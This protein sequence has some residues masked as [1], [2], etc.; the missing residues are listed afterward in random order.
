MT[1]FKKFTKVIYLKESKK[2]RTSHQIL[3][4]YYVHC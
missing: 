3:W 4:E 2:N 1:G